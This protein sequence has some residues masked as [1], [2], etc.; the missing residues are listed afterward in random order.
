MNDSCSMLS[1]ST[2]SHLILTDSTVS[3]SVEPNPIKVQTRSPLSKSALLKKTSVTTADAVKPQPLLVNV[4]SCHANPVVAEGSVQNRSLNVFT[5]KSEYLC[6][7][8]MEVTVFEKA[9]R[10]W[11]L[12]TEQTESTQVMDQRLPIMQLSAIDMQAP[13]VNQDS[14]IAYQ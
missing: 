6:E 5:P 4:P 3:S 1:I 13:T 2:A 12:V 7:P 14:T 11:H 8:F 9:E 10:C